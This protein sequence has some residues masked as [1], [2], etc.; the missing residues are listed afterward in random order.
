[1]S[2]VP[3]SRPGISDEFLKDA[4]CAHVGDN[5]CLKLFGFRAEGIALPFHHANGS[6]ILDTNNPFARVRLYHATD[7]QKYHQRPG[8]GIHVY[9]PPRFAQSGKGSR[10][11]LVE[12]EFKSLALA[13]AG[14]AALG[15]CGITGAAHT[16]TGAD[17]ERGHVLH[18]ELVDLLQ[19]HQPAHVV[20]LGDA[21]V[22]LNAQFAVE[23]AKLRR[24]L[25]ASKQFRFIEKFTVAMLPLDGAKGVDDLRAEKA[26]AFADCF[27]AILTNGYGVPAKASST[28][29]FVASLKR[30]SDAVKRLV[31]QQ[32]H[33]GSRARI[34]LLE[35]AAQLWRQTGAP[36]ELRPLLADVLGVRKSEV[37]GLVR[38]AANKQ[39]SHEPAKAEAKDTAQGR[40]LNLP[41][42]ELWQGVVNGVDVLNEIAKTFPR[43]VVLFDA[44]ADAC[45]LWAAHAHCVDCFQC[46]PR[47]NIT[48]PDKR[49][50]KTTLRDV[51]ALFV[52]RPLATENLSVAVLFRVIEAHKPTVLADECDA[53]LRDNEEIRGMLNAGHRRG[54]QALRCEGDSNE[55]R[56]F[57]VY[58]PTVLCGIGSLPGTLHDRSIVIQ[59]ERAK[60]SELRERFDSRRTQREQ[61]LCRKLARWCYDNRARL[62]SCDPALP[63][64]AFNRIADNWRPLFAVAEVAGG[65][66]PQRAANAFAKLT[67]QEDADAQG[68][69]MMLLADIQQ[70]FNEAHAER[71]FSKQLVDS[72]CLMSDR[73]WPEANGKQGKPISETWLARQLHFFHVNPKTLRIG[74]ARAKGYEL[75]DFRDAFDRYLSAPGFSNRD[76]VTTT[77]FTG[78]KPTSESVT[79]QGRVTDA[80]PHE[81]PVNSGL[82]RCHDSNSPNKK[83]QAAEMLL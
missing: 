5:D 67:S 1:M 16:I 20:F 65:E 25:F 36:L 34:R 28:E 73:P 77:D 57:N 48:S 83:Q 32:D 23:A 66:W 40:A 29:I 70:A 14:Y 42:V 9:I 8:S 35:S 63:S 52:P 68:I 50:G 79:T 12:G 71:I 59:L 56:A 30:E 72:L 2:A 39:Q 38:D 21:D 80:K 19:M 46:S 4:G 3:F 61:E 62:E 49:C 6:P 13:E 81:N 78:G 17:G 15:L 11:I 58:A 47:L 37:V 76:T 69:R 60:P 7:A 41:D 75:A 22:V 33:E 18:D 43:Y 44:V 64:G 24:L 31:T 54:G 27:E 51:L 74:D 55:V 82:S 53:W 26:D 45:T 10:L